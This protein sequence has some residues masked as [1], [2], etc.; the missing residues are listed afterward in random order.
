M[1]LRFG[2]NV[3]GLVV[4][5]RVLRAAV[6][7]ENEVRAVA[8]VTLVIAAVAFCF[9][10][11]EQ[12]YVPLQVA[13]SFFL[14]E[15]VLRTTLGIRYSPAGVFARWLT[16]GQEPHWVSAKPKR[17]AW[18]IGVAMAFSMTVITNTGIRGA[19]PGTLCA[20]CMTLM[21]MEAAL[22]LCLGCKAYAWLVRHGYKSRDD[23]IEVCAGGVCAL[24]V[25]AAPGAAPVK[26]S[27][28]HVTV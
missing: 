2:Q 11:F 18:M 5:G 17:F 9:A 25:P 16:R 15:F 22:G 19:L 20:I 12:Q 10:L 8:G 1:Q 13:S 14:V 26:A 24:P 23:E 28:Q 7:N 6:F 4:G 3:A 21:W 27:E